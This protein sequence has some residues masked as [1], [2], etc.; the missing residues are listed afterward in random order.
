MEVESFAQCQCFTP[1]RSV[2]T[3]SPVEGSLTQYDAAFTYTSS[4]CPENASVYMLLIPT[5]HE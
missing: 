5:S 4:K 1:A 2:R 3:N